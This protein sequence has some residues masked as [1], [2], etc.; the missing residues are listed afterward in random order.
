MLKQV[1]FHVNSAP[2]CFHRRRESLLLCFAH[3]PHG[4]LSAH[5]RDTNEPT[6]QGDT[7]VDTETQ[8]LTHAHAHTPLF[9]DQKML[10]VPKII[11]V[12]FS[13]VHNSGRAV[14]YECCQNQIRLGFMY[15]SDRR[16]FQS[17]AFYRLSLL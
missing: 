16:A 15:T 1:F 11:F 9:V 12:T 5:K 8:T 14:F 10:M 13:C 4:G 2:C 6:Q 17:F 3:C 7:H